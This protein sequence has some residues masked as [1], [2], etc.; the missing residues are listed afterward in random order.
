MA[1]GPT[2]HKQDVIMRG[3]YNL[4]VDRK[5]IY[6]IFCSNT[7]VTTFSLRITAAS[8]ITVMRYCYCHVRTF[9]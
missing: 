6:L 9:D 5:I 4:F 2:I 8:Y 7:N 1:N 3:R